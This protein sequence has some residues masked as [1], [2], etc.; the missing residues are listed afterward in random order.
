MK[1]P[2]ELSCVVF[3]TIYYG[4]SG[5]TIS[6]PGQNSVF[7]ANKTTIRIWYDDDLMTDYLK[8]EAVA[9]NDSHQRIRVE[10]VLISGLEY[11]EAIN[12]ASVEGDDYP[13]LFIITNDSLEKAYLAGLATEITGLGNAYPTAAISAV[14][15]QG[16]SVAYPYYFETSSLL[17]NKTDLE[18]SARSSLEA[19]QDA[20][21]GEAAMSLRHP[22]PL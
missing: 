14:T 9:Y 22:S 5:Q 6:A 4:L 13:D 8:S 21:A 18:K 1:E 19:Q 20:A 2:E 10:P 11:L 12:R 15:Y 3:I 17:Y 7:S 16:K